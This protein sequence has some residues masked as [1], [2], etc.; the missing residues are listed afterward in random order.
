MIGEVD[1]DLPIIVEESRNPPKQQPIILA[2][3]EV[4]S[5]ANYLSDVLEMSYRKP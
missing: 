1:V 5:D 4:K 3:Y 2:K